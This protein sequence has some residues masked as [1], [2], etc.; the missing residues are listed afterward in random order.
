MIYQYQ[1]DYGAGYEDAFQ[2]DPSMS[3]QVVEPT[4]WLRAIETEGAA[5]RARVLSGGEV[6][7]ERVFDCIVVSSRVRP[8]GNTQYMVGCSGGEIVV[9]KSMDGNLTG[10]TAPGYVGDVDQ[11]M[12]RAF[13][14][15]RALH[16]K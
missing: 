11:A 7:E 12:E 15:V 2:D 1:I 14:A 13:E 8:N 16:E 5:R 3:N 10:D 6:I 4:A 9:E